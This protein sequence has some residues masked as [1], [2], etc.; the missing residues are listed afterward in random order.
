LLAAVALLAVAAC[1]STGWSGE[2]D[3][4]FRDL[5]SALEGMAEDDAER[6]RLRDLARQIETL[7]RELLAKHLAFQEEFDAGTADPAVAVADLRRRTNDYQRDRVR[8]RDE[9]LRVQGELRSEL[10]EADW[11]A[12][13][14]TLS[15]GAAILTRSRH[16]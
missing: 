3:A 9:L 10:S 6:D 14:D 12:V 4:A 2:L 7:G 13:I 5:S 11:G 1:G 8:M 16:E 15:C